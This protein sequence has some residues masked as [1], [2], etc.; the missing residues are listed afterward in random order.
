MKIRHGQPL[1][2]PRMIWTGLLTGVVGMVL[3]GVGVAVLSWTWS[4]IGA[5]LL[6]VGITV[7]IGN[8][9]LY[10]AHTGPP[11]GEVNDILQGGTRHGIA[12]RQERSTE[13][14]RLKA[15]EVEDR[16]DNLKTS[17][18]QAPRPSPARPAGIVLVVVAAFLFVSQWTLYPPELPGQTNALRALGCAI[19]LAA[20]GLRIAL[21]R[22]H[23]SHRPSAAIA[24][25]AGLL[26]LFNGFLS[27]HDSPVTPVT[28]CICGSLVLVSAAI[29]LACRRP[30]SD[31]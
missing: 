26:L 2:R 7:A 19:V 24:G 29:V 22:P 14:S 16:L 18:M 11:T 10:D 15:I 30:R 6:L 23:R 1:T 8:G 28:E 17:T 9:I 21:G 25:V 27:A 12:P 31:G 3:A 13:R 20:C 5:G 4:L